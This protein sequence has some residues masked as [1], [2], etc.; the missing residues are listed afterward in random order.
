MPMIEGVLLAARLDWLEGLLPLLFVLVWVVSQV[1][2]VF[3]K[4]AGGDAAR[5]AAPPGRVG[6]RPPPDGIEPAGDRPGE[7][8]REIEEFLR[9]SL[10][11]SR[12]R[13]PA[14]PSPVTRAPKPKSRLAKAGGP[15]R[16]PTVPPLPQRDPQGTDIARHV[17]SAFAHDLAHES[18]SFEPAATAPASVSPTV[19][20][21]TL[22]RSP[23]GLRQ[24]VL[25]RE[26]LE[27]PTQRWDR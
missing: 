17:E 13:E 8:D 11:G 23:A 5:R 12:Q 27:R 25:M 20:M 3:R 1:M 14:Q 10:G 21:A 18:P 26:I 22:I 4:A 9:R 2:G 24:L 15:P 16:L 6:R 19:D 7:I